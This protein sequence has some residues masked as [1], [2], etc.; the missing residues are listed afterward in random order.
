MN[1]LIEEANKWRLSTTTIPNDEY[2]AVKRENE[3]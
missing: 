1:I 3:L 2:A